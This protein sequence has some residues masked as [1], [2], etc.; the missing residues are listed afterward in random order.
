M[1]KHIVDLFKNLINKID[2]LNN[3]LFSVKHTLSNINSN[4][5]S[6]T[7]SIENIEIELKLQNMNRVLNHN[8][9]ENENIVIKKQLINDIINNPMFS[10]FNKLDVIKDAPIVEDEFM[11]L[12]SMYPPIK[13]EIK[14]NEI[15]EVPHVHP[16]ENLNC[17]LD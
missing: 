17:P 8:E 14:S 2:D 16:F 3:E 12:L 1:D 10:K 7:Q 13:K 15:I 5:Y 11:R 6:L 4:I 9:N